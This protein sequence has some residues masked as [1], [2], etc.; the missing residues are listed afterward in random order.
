MFLTSRFDFPLK[1]VILPLATAAGGTNTGILG[2]TGGAD[3]GDIVSA[4]FVGGGDFKSA[5]GELIMLF[6]LSDLATDVELFCE[7]PLFSCSEFC[8]LNLAC[9]C[10]CFCKICK[11]FWLSN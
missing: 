11:I 6:I 1:A 5:S 2:G 8:C 10:S 9:F 4:L 7:P 3:G